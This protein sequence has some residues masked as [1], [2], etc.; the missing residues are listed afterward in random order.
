MG[1]DSCLTLWFEP[2]YNRWLSMRSGKANKAVSI[3]VKNGTT[4]LS[5]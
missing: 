2:A 5:V 4:H 3:V 1:P